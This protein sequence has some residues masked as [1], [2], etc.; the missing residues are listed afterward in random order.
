MIQLD[1]Q[2]ER[3]LSDVAKV[4]R[5]YRGNKRADSFLKSAR[6][7]V[8]FS[9]TLHRLFRPNHFR[10]WNERRIRGEA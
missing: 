5:Q 10:R 2:Q 7:I 6:R 3:C 4:V 1:E 9:L 8:I